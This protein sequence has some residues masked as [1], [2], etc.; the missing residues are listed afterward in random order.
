MIGMAE[1]RVRAP[2]AL[3]GVT[4]CIAA[5]K[6]C[7]VVRGLQKAGC[8]VRVAMTEAATAFVGPLTFEA[9]T[10]RP[11]LVDLG[12]FADTPIGHV[13][14]AEWADLVLVC[15]ATA[16]VLAKAVAGVADDALTSTL[17][18]AW[19]HVAFAPA[20]NVHMWRSPATQA[21]VATLRERGAH[22]VMPATGRL[23]CGDVGEGKLADVEEVVDHALRLLVRA[24]VP[25]RLAGRRVVVTAGPTHEAIDPVRYVANRSSGKMGYAVARAARDAGAEVTLVTGPSALRA[26]AGCEVVRVTS[27]REMLEAATSAFEGAD[28]AVCAAAVAD[29]TP[30]A[31]ADHKLKKD[32][33]R[34][35][36]LEMRET[37]DVLATLSAAKGGRVVVG[38]AA[39][40]G[41]PVAAAR[42]KLERKGCDLIVAND[43]SRADS[44]FGTD[45]D[46]VTIVGPDGASEHPCLPK[47][48][49]AR[50]I[51]GRV[52]DLL[53]A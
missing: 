28:A 45:T 31:P 15:P 20:M 8:E 10:G 19:D 18:A 16:D 52:A 48:E 9:L 13:E 17:V 39:E 42:S 51:V 7:E 11:V 4:G 3:V 14:L 1:D 6:A 49:V 34:L 29:Y 26:P 25:Q 23:A 21:N 46:A 24:V 36:V 27:A 47:D 41:D 22:L 50:L 30:A 2:R 12:T 43:V 44:G 35:D 38:F 40:T 53:G 32:A 33:E 5:Y 37:A